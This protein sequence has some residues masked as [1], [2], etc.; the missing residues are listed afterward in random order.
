MRTTENAVRAIIDVTDTDLT[1]YIAVANALVTEYC[2]DVSTYD[3]ERLEL[4]ERWLSAHFCTIKD[5]RTTAEK[6]GSVSVNY[7]SVIDLGFNSSHYGQTAM[8]LDTNGGLAALNDK[9]NKA[10]AANATV[11]WLGTAEE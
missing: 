1:P 9:I 7:Q 2:A 10:K 5:P 11:T 4:I 3:A 6:I 8:R